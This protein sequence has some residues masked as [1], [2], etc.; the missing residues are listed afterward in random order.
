MKELVQGHWQ[1]MELGQRHGSVW[2][3]WDKDMAVDG[4]VGT[5]TCGS[6]GW[7]GSALWEAS[8]KDIVHACVP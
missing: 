1:G 3:S 5:E 7:Q 4:V 8:P 6:Q 2:R